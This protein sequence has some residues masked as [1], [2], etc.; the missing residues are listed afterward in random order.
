MTEACHMVARGGARAA[1]VIDFLV[2]A[3][4]PVLG[5]ELPALREASRLMDRYSDVPMDFADASLVVLGHALSIS[6]AFTIDRRGFQAYRTAR[7]SAFQLHPA[8]L[9]RRKS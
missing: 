6:T 1:I 7:G 4:I 5:L 9:S 8:R 3:E 2:A